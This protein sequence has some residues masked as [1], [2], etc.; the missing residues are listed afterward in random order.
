MEEL[1]MSVKERRKMELLAQVMKHKQSLIAD[2]GA[3][4]PGV[5]EISYQ[6]FR[7]KVTTCFGGK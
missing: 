5:S 2:F 6:G 4:L 7:G 1:R 3:K